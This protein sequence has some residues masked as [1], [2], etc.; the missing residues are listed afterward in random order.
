MLS[1]IDSETFFFIQPTYMH[2]L[3]LK[4][5]LFMHM[6]ALWMRIVC[7]RQVHVLSTSNACESHWTIRRKKSRCIPIT[8]YRSTFDMRPM[9][10]VHRSSS[11]Q[12]FLFHFTGECGRY[13]YFIDCIVSKKFNT[14]QHNNTIQ[15][16]RL[17]CIHG[18]KW[19]RTKGKPE[20]VEKA[21]TKKDIKSGLTTRARVFIN[22]SAY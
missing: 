22:T 17:I 12:Q 19:Y 13:F 6:V 1:H 15:R 4:M 16:Q 10:C 18:G 9:S 20:K 3:S 11:H 5:V 7:Y 2:Y 14:T 8:I 21:I